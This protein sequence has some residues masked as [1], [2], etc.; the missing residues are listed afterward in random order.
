M[1]KKARSIT[2]AQPLQKRCGILPVWYT[3]VYVDGNTVWDIE[4]IRCYQRNR[5]C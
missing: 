3:G 4:L 5:V 1:P 2:V